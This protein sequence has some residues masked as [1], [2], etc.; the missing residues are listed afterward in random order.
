MSIEIARKKFEAAKKRVEDCQRAIIELQKKADS[1]QES[2]PGLS[3][4]IEFTEKAK[5]QAL[6]DHALLENRESESRLKQARLSHEKAQKDVIETSELVEATCR[7]LKRQQAELIRLNEVC[8]QG[9][10]AVWAAIADDLRLKIPAEMIEAIRQFALV[11]FT[12]IG[13]SYDFCLKSIFPQPG[14]E[15]G[16]AI[17]QGFREK[18]GID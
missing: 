11:S 12:Q 9:K 2:L 5:V 15:E 10:R 1:L 18:Y 17:L 3:R 7:A 14:H 4:L 8:G 6:D 13:G 16:I